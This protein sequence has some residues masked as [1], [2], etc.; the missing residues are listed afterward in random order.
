MDALFGDRA[1]RLVRRHFPHV[2]VEHEQRTPPPR[3][4]SATGA[5]WPVAMFDEIPDTLR[6]PVYR[7]LIKVLHPDAGGD[8]AA[9]K[10]LTTAWHIIEK[11]TP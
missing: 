11:R 1:E 6:Q 7:A 9:T 4:S 3:T 8:L 10:K 2:D 5:E